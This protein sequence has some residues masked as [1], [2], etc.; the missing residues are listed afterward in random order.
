[1]LHRS[2]DSSEAPLG[3]RPLLSKVGAVGQ[4]DEKDRYLRFWDRS[5]ERGDVG[6]V[7]GAGVETYY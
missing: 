1:M 2:A 4:A 5:R 6:F 7:A 3:R